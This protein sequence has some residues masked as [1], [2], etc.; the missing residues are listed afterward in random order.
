M[1]A[2]IDATATSEQ[3]SSR[4]VGR[5]L[6]II[7]FLAVIAYV[8]SGA[9]Y[10]VYF[11]GPISSDHGRWAEFGDFLGGTL[12]PVF[13]FLSLVA[14]L[15]TLKIQSREFS[16]SSRELKDSTEVLRKQSESLQIRNFESTFFELLRLYNEGV[17]SIDFFQPSL[18]GKANKTVG[19]DCFRVF[20]LDGLRFEYE[21]KSEGTTTRNASALIRAAY[22]KFFESYQHDIGHCFR[23]LYHVFKFINESNIPDS[24]RYASIMRAQLSTY[25]LALL[26]YNGLHP[27]GEKFKPL[28]EK[29]ALLEN[30]GIGI[31][32]N[33]D[34]HVPLYDPGAYGDNKEAQLI[35]YVRP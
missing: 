28:I 25:E 3:D 22:D 9:V 8:L 5:N 13:G 27:V 21:I 19:R 26:F 14:I 7:L 4:V 31:L 6:S 16:I 12:S 1:N 24:R 11:H 15:I 20:Y 32:L 17:Q 18:R 35:F 30:L 34:E 2:K 29:F 23:T 33:A 10:M